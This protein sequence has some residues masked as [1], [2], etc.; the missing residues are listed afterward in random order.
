MTDLLGERRIRNQLDILRELVRAQPQELLPDL[1]SAA[2]DELLRRDGWN[3]SLAIPASGWNGNNATLPVVAGTYAEVTG[4]WRELLES[5]R[6]EIQRALPCVG[7]LEWTTQGQEKIEGTGWRVRDDMVVTN[8]HI[9]EGLL[10]TITQPNARLRIDFVEEDENNVEAAEHAPERAGEF[11]VV[12]VPYMAPEGAL[13]LAFVRIE[14]RGDARRPVI[15]LGEDPQAGTKV[16]AIGYPAV[17]DTVYDAVLGPD[18]FSQIFG[19]LLGVKRVSPGTIITTAADRVVH[20]CATAGGSSGSVILDP[21]SGKAVALN[22]GE[23]GRV[24]HAVPV[25]IIRE[26]LA[27]IP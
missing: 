11:R 26:R 16:C 23:D 15:E 1:T 3:M 22:Y 24:N 18:Y 9:A 10:E 5:R 12:D 14:T 6:P 7:R 4:I 21:A 8:R 27:H 19:F 20:D 25:S 13:D 17:R 2:I